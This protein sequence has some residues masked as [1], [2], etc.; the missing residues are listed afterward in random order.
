MIKT[1]PATSQAIPFIQS[2]YSYNR[3]TVDA[4]AAPHTLQR[5]TLPILLAL[6]LLALLLAAPA[7]QADIYKTVLPDGTVV[8]SDHP[9]EGQEPNTEKLEQVDVPTLNFPSTKKTTS[10]SGY[11]GYNSSKATQPAQLNYNSVVIT[12]PQQDAT[13][14]NIGGTLSVSV[15]ID[16]A[17]GRG[18]QLVLMKNGSQAAGPTRSS[19]LTAT[20]VFRGS[21]TFTVNIVDSQ[22]TITSSNAVTVHAHQT[23]AK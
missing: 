17:L 16:P 3:L 4:S 15:S 21:H 12:S 20:D 9:E 23:S 22:Q 19:R 14:R 8:Y 1:V 7:A 6:A 13:Y 18:H 5:N 2:I 11:S 10:S